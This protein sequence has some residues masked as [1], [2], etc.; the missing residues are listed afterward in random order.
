MK[1]Y[2]ALDLKKTSTQKQVKEKLKEY[3]STH[4]P[5]S[6]I[7]LAFRVLT[8]IES[9]E[10]YDAF[11]E[12]YEQE[13]QHKSIVDIFIAACDNC[14][15]N[16]AVYLLEH[17]IDGWTI[18]LAEFIKPLSAEKVEK[19]LLDSFT[20][21]TAAAAK[22]M[23]HLF[24]LLLNIDKEINIESVLAKALRPESYNKENFFEAITTLRLDG[25]VPQLTEK[26]LEYLERE[27]SERY[28]KF[29][30]ALLVMRAVLRRTFLDGRTVPVM[31]EESVSS[32]LPSLSPK[33][34]GGKRQAP[35][36]PDESQSSEDAADPQTQQDLKKIVKSA[37]DGI[38]N[39]P[40]L[41]LS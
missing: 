18:K 26:V 28:I 10:A 20:A 39:S 30:G 15:V 8:S 11:I 35:S 9:R 3:K 38:S 7:D 22:K 6:D 34:V 17:A 25:K 1:F 23:K 41:G 24:I 13:S 14:E 2:I 33:K 40:R 32:P 4:N 19:F 37:V 29:E 36:S 31:D 5:S 21:F 16:Y 27:S 12:R